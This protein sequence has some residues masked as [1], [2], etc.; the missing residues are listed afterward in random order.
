[1]GRVVKKYL[2]D[3]VLLEESSEVGSKEMGGPR[4]AMW[5]KLLQTPKPLRWKCAC[6]VSEAT[7]RPVQQI[8]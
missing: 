7:K 1:M 5:E 2:S 4:D 6:Q 8:I 3:K